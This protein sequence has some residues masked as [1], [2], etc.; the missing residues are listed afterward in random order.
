MFHGLVGLR[1]RR[2]AGAT[3]DRIPDPAIAAGSQ[4]GRES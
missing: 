4:S 1:T 2:Q 3:H